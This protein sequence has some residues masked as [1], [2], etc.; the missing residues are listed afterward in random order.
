MKKIA[1]F[2]LVCILCSGILLVKYKSEVYAMLMVGSN[3]LKEM[4]FQEK[5]TVKLLEQEKPLSPPLNK[6]NERLVEKEEPIPNQDEQ[7][8]ATTQAIDQYLQS[9]HYNGVAY[10]L[11]QGKEL[12][13]QSYGYSNFDT[14]EVL[15]VERP[16]PMASVS[17]YV[18]AISI[19]QLKEKGLLSTSDKLSK[20]YH[21]SSAKGKIEIKQLLNHTSGIVGGE[22]NRT[23]KMNKWQLVKAVLNAPLK[24]DPGTKWIYSDG[25]YILLSGIIEKV[26]KQNLEEY[27]NQNIFNPLQIHSA[28]Y[29]HGNYATMQSEKKGKVI[30][31]LILSKYFGCGNLIINAED[32]AKL[33]NGLTTGKLVTAKTVVEMERPS[34]PSRRYGYGFYN[35]NTYFYNHGVYGKSGFDAMNL[36][37]NKG[38]QVILF[39]NKRSEIDTVK[40]AEEIFE[41]I[42]SLKEE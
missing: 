42:N 27:V 29:E 39:T 37:T 7:D 13:K 28:Y 8:L 9:K 1:G 25:N 19:L 10:V 17:K 14:N 26:S 38:D 18:V 3:S 21:T 32:L 11:H 6:P 2:L 24:A 20:Y 31:G 5:D 4:Y 12:L 30:E 33:N 40:M 23:D 16:F 15:D 41:M 22:L 36:F 34:P 35:M